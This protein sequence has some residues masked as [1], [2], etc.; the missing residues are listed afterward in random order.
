MSVANWPSELGEFMRTPAGADVLS[1]LDVLREHHFLNL[2]RN[3]RAASLEDMRYN[4]GVCDGI[5]QIRSMLHSLRRH[6]S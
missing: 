3:A 2:A 4:I 6:G 5:E 1:R